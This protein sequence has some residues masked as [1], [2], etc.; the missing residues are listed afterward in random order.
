MVEK[1]VMGNTMLRSCA[2]CVV[3]CFFCGRELQ[4]CTGYVFCF[5][6]DLPIDS[7]VLI[8]IVGHSPKYR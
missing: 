8:V 3:L 2:C 7:I 6:F 5:V 1:L 4:Y